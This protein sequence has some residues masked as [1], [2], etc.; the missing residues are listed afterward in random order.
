MERNYQGPVGKIELDNINDLISQINELISK[1]ENSD[2][3]IELLE[4]S[5]Y[6]TLI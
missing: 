6:Q 1:N 5:Y 4:K 2:Q 3:I